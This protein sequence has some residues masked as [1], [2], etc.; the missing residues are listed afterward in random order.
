MYIFVG[1]GGGGGVVVTSTFKNN[2][3]VTECPQS[4]RAGYT[5]GDYTS[6]L[7]GLLQAVARG[8]QTKKLY[9]FQGFVI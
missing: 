8:K 9:L 2:D 3:F 5:T 6:L 1:G 7:D 4:Q